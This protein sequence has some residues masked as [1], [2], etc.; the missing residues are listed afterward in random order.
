MKWFLLIFGLLSS[1]AVFSQGPATLSVS[2][3][4]ALSSYI[5]DRLEAEDV[6]CS[7]ILAFVENYLQLSS[8]NQLLLNV[9]ANRLLAKRGST[10][11]R[12]V[13][14]SEGVAQGVSTDSCVSEEPDEQAELACVVHFIEEN[15]ATLSEQADVILSVLPLCLTSSQ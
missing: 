10:D 3:M 5:G 11:A 13:R 4:E 2:E 9:S 15:E 6:D 12:A 1:G 7:N 8:A 14:D